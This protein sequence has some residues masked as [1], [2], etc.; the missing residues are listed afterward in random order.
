VLLLFSLMYLRG[1]APVSFWNN[2][3]CLLKFLVNWYVRMCEN[4][5]VDFASWLHVIFSYNV[6]NDYMYVCAD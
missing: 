4:V 2:M 1:R 3:L 6:T 5:R